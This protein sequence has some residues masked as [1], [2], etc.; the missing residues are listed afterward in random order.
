MKNK[1][2]II[3]MILSILL[4][5]M[6]TTSVFAAIEPPIDFDFSN[7]FENTTDGNTTDGN[8]TPGNTTPENTTGNTNTNSMPNSNIPYAGPEDTILM[9]AAFVVCA[10][11]G[12]YTFIKLSEYSNI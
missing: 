7:D 9:G 2:I 3:T 10:I 6:I 11:I 5:G 8:T 12:I 4:M 1:K